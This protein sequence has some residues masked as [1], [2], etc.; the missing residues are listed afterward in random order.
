M[1]GED[2]KGREGN[3]PCTGLLAVLYRNITVN[4]S[5]ILSILASFCGKLRLGSEE[6][7][8]LKLG[9]YEKVVSILYFNFG[10]ITKSFQTILP[11]GKLTFFCGLTTSKNYF[12]GH[13]EKWQIPSL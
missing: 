7:A 5:T 4:K 12:P 1:K 9:E 2:E 8:E 11:L 3:I 6:M 10:K 13:L